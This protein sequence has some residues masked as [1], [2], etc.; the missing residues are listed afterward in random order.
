MSTNL[1]SGNPDL[2]NRIP[3]PESRAFA[4]VVLP[5]PLDQPFTYSVPAPLRHRIAVGM[6]VVVP[7]QKRVETGTVVELAADSSVENIRALIDLTASSLFVRIS[8]I[9]GMCA[10][11]YFS[12]AALGAAAAFARAD[13]SAAA[14]DWKLLSATTS[15]A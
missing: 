5:L 6:R 4:Q 1:E 12:A 2:D 15:A 14:L 3:I 11:S 9:V 13:C 8:W 7:F 10:D